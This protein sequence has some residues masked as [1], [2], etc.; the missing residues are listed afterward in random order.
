M[1]SI[2][3]VIVGGETH[4]YRFS[5]ADGKTWLVPSH[6]LSTALQLY[7]PGGAKGKLLKSLF[8]YLH[9]LKPVRALLHASSERVALRTDIRL[10]LEDVFGHNEFGFSMFGGTPSVHQ[11]IT[12]Q[13]S[14][15]KKILGYCKLT[16]SEAIRKLFLHEKALL[17]TLHEAGLEGIPRCIGCSTLSD[18]TSFFVQSTVKTSRSFSPY[19]WTP[20]HEAFLKRMSELT[21]MSVKF[22]KSDL[23]ISLLA[24]KTNI[25]RIPSGMRQ[26]IEPVLDD[27]L[28][29][30]TGNTMEYSA[31][32]ADFTPWNMFIENEGL[33]VFDW[34]Y[35]RMTY[36]PMLDRYHFFI[37]QSLHVAHLAPE[38]IYS[39]LKRLSWFD[40][41][42]YRMYLLDI[43]SR[44][45]MREEG[46]LSPA[47]IGMLHNWCTLLAFR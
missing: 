42:E 5:N 11:K 38:R 12:L 35:G 23:G 28:K 30:Y 41:N 17:D 10:M 43:I 32:H 39:G 7:Q 40:S 34:E 22:E 45:T 9:W 19:L 46:K 26:V 36:P 31:F 2:D 1:L 33:F 6:E 29:E 25:A 27:I 4:A 18:G 47:L 3:S 16:D 20:L 24:L 13:V 44:F 37:Q 21:I 14:D 15:G 8:P